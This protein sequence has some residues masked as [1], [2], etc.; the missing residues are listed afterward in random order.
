[1]YRAKERQLS[2]NRVEKFGGFY[3]ERMCQR[4]DVY[5]RDIL[6]APLDAA[7]VIAMQIR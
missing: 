4:N 5:D 7:N 6:L 2:Q 3:L 1:M